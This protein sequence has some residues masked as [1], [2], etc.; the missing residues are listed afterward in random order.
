MTTTQETTERIH[1]AA[2]EILLAS[3]VRRTT[4]SDVARRAEVSRMSIY[5]R[6]PDLTALVREV[7]TAE[8]AALVERAT[9]AG[10]DEAARTRIVSQ[11]TAF[12]SELRANPVWQKIVDDEPALL[13]PYMLQRIGATQALAL[14]LIEQAV[15]DGQRDG[16]IRHGDVRTIAQGVLLGAQSFAYSAQLSEDVPTEHVLAELPKLLDR[17]LAPA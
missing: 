9:V 8:F 14:K 15:A 16:S 1:E 5:R 6:Y 7:L 13:L 4:L 17:Y 2:R 3:G 12:V 11:V 10:E